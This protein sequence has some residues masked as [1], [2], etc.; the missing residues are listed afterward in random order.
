MY[1]FPAV[2]QQH[3]QSKVC[4]FIEQFPAVTTGSVYKDSGIKLLA[5]QPKLQTFQIG[6]KVYNTDQFSG[7]NKVQRLMKIFFILYLS[8]CIPRLHWTTSVPYITHL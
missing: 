7:D 6:H 2:Q 8:S 5:C 3:I 4:F 1:F